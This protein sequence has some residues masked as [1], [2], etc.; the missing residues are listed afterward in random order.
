MKFTFVPE[1]RFETFDLAT[2]DAQTRQGFGITD[3][4]KDLTNKGVAYCT[5]QTA[6]MRDKVSL[7]NA[8]SKPRKIKEVINKTIRL[9]HIYIDAITLTDDK[10]G[11]FVT[12][13]RIVL[14]DDK[15]QGY[16]AVSM[17]MYES[18]KRLIQMFGEPSEWAKPL[19]VEIVPIDLKNGG[20]TYNLRAVFEG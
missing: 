11:A 9:A 8:I 4:K 3:I 19:T 6:S 17:G 15:A 16:Q 12:A 1:Y 10:T 13:P 7:Y 5:M 18:V 14:I 2:V 20:T